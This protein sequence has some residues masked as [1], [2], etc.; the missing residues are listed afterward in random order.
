M[1]DSSTCSTTPS[2][3]WQ[4]CRGW[5]FCLGALAPS[6]YGLG[7]CASVVVLLC[8]FG[9]GTG[10][11]MIGTA[12]RRCR[13]H[14]AS[15]PMSATLTS[16]E[17]MSDFLAISRPAALLDAENTQA[18]EERHRPKPVLLPSHNWA[19]TFALCSATGTQV[20]G[21]KHGL[22]PV[23]HPPHNSGV[24]ALITDAQ[25]WNGK[26]GLKPALQPPPQLGGFCFLQC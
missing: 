15:Q 5:L 22:R 1:T 3:I 4:L 13:G 6:S 10:C 16:R 7:P 25:V 17:G 11:M 18:W 20:L 24:L 14:P 8:P 12:K 21:R 23:L 2:L 9:M 19:V 26:R